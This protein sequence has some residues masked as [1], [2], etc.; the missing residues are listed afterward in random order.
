MTLISNNEELE[1]HLSTDN[2]LLILFGD[3][4]ETVAVHNKLMKMKANKRPIAKVA[5]RPPPISIKR[6]T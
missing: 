5:A 1:Q 3:D 4:T 6:F 2:T